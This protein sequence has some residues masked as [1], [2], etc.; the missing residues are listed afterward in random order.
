MLYAL[1]YNM[2]VHNYVMC[3]HRGLPAGIYETYNSEDYY[4]VANNCQAN[5]IVVEKEDQ[6]DKIL[7]VTCT[8]CGSAASGQLSIEL[9]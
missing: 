8:F 4:F 6:V 1:L 2:Y 3:I 7:K 9:V 5:I